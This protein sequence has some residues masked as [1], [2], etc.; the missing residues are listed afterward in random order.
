MTP[1][2]AVAEVSQSANGSLRIKLH[3]KPAA[4]E[5]T[6][7]AVDA[8]RQDQRF[9]EFDPTGPDVF[10]LFHTPIRPPERS[11]VESVGIEELARQPVLA[12][13]AQGNS[14]CGIVGWIDQAP[15][16]CFLHKLILSLAAP[17]PVS[18]SH[19]RGGD[20]RP[21]HSPGA[22][23]VRPPPCRPRTAARPSCS[24]GPHLLGDCGEDAKHDRVQTVRGEHLSARVFESSGALN[25]LIRGHVAN[26]AR[27]RRDERIRIRIS[28]R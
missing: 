12:G 26:N 1:P 8:L 5:D 19:S 13:L 20:L 6:Q 17:R 28:V 24:P 9:A 22:G 25:R 10:S 4:L 27:D 14:L 23:M 21:H 7:K 3:D 16:K 2:A 15:G 11:G 18:S